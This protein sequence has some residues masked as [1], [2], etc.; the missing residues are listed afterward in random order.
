MRQIIN[1]SLPEQTVKAVKRAVKDGE[2]V[3][4]SEFFRALLRS[5]QEGNLLSELNASRAEIRA[6]K[7]KTL[8]SLKDLA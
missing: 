8:R 2:F 1:I 3:S 7:G 4:T 5:W 6:G